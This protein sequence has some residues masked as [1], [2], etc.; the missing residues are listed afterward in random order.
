MRMGEGFP[1]TSAGENSMAR[2]AATAAS[3]KPCPAPC[4]TTTAVTWPVASMSMVSVTSPESPA[5]KA[6]GG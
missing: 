3:S 6:S 4:A 1:S 2:A 5:A